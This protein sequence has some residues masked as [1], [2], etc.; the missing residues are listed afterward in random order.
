MKRKMFNPAEGSI[1]RR[2]FVK[3]TALAFA[4]VGATGA[5]GL[6][7]FP[8]PGLRALNNA[9]RMGHCAPSVMQSLLQ[10]QGIADQELVLSSGALAGGIAGPDTECGCLTA[11][12]MF[13][14]YQDAAVASSTEKLLLIDKSQ[15][16][17]QEFAR[18]YG[19]TL[20]GKI[21]QG[22]LSSCQKA[23]RSFHRPYASAM[24]GPSM[25]SAEKEDAYGLLL[26]AFEDHSFHCSQSVF[27]NLHDKFS[28]APAVHRSSWIYIGGIAMLNKTCGAL[29]AGVMAIGSV[30]AK[31]ENSYARVARMN[32]L[33][34]R[35]RV[36]EAMQ[37]DINHFNRSILLSDELGAWFRGEYGNVTC[38][39]IWGFSFA[40]MR[41]AESFVSG[42]CLDHCKQIACRVA[43]KV[44]TTDFS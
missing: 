37:E 25:L 27:H 8:P 15:R 11:P 19:S 28:I 13:T 33:L 17:V 4:A 14:S 6:T 5:V 20:C 9:L 39:G 18:C 12:M 7:A 21:R 36:N 26:K 34:S 44:N 41:E 35:G 16:Y 24:A 1:S 22:G 10:M 43:E 29:A 38:Q 31:M 30:A 23:M 42:G 32:R 40:K 3:R 2:A